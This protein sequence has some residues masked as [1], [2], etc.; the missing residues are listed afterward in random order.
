MTERTGRLNLQ[1]TSQQASPLGPKG[2]FSGR[3]LKPLE[4]KPCENEATKSRSDWMTK[5]LQG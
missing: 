2:S 5:S 3:T 1:Y 4:E